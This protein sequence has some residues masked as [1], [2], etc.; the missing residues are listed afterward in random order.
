MASHKWPPIREG[1][2]SDIFQK[3]KKILCEIPS[4]LGKKYAINKKSIYF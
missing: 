4:D 2:N 1:H 3:K